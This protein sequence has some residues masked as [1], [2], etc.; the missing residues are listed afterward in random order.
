ML[1]LFNFLTYQ[2][3]SKNMV[4]VSIKKMYYSKRQIVINPPQNTSPHFEHTYPNVFAIFR[5]SSGSPLSWV[6]LVVLSWLPRCPESIHGHFDFGEEPE[7]TRC[8]IQ[9]IRWMTTHHNIFD[10]NCCTRSD[11]WH[12]ALSWWGMKLF[13]HLSVRF[14]HTSVLK[15]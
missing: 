2:V 3:S 4:N 10:R 15:L 9:W 12:T 11:V 6:S 14:L 5:S 13:A 1:G 8:Q 7:V